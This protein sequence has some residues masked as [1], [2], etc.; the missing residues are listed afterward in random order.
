MK[1]RFAVTVLLLAIA[2]VSVFVPT[3]VGNEQ[4]IAQIIRSE[5][6]WRKVYEQIPDLPR[7]NQ[8]I[9]RETGKVAEEN[10]LVSR[11]I[12]YHLYVRG[13]PPFYR[14]DWKITLAEYL[15]LSGQ[16]DDS[17]Y[18]SGKRLNKNPLEG[19]LAAIRKLNRSQRD[20]L[21]QALVDAF[22]PQSTRSRQVVPKPVIQLPPGAKE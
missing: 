17:D 13:R 11:L 12:R 5:G 21:V 16:V 19:D 2:P 22:V 8:Y 9:D 3:F 1:S 15:G 20:A 7:E 4:A 10:T 18:P 6:A 14:L